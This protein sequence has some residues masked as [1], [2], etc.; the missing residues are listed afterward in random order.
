M[1]ETVEKSFKAIK[2]AA[3]NNNIKNAS[4]EVIAK[5]LRAVKIVLCHDFTQDVLA[6]IYL[7]SVKLQ[8]MTE[9]DQLRRR[10]YMMPRESIF[11]EMSVPKSGEH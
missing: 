6:R 9:T 3:Q 2:T 8:I 5:Q 7:D 11:L 10:I 4:L 1:R